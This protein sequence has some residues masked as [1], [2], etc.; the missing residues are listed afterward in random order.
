MCREQDFNRSE[1]TN[2][3]RKEKGVEALQWE[4]GRE[5][6]VSCVFIMLMMSDSLTEELVQS[7]AVSV[8][9][10][11]PSAPRHCVSVYV[12][13]ALGSTGAAL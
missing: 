8:L 9:D 2:T 7:F 4:M 1:L 3:R 11:S 12:K 13:F 5:D 10:S 6:S